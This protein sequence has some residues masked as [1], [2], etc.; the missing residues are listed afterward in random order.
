MCTRI[1]EIVESKA[2]I[3][4]YCFREKLMIRILKNQS[5]L[6]SERSYTYIFGI[7]SVNYYVSVG[8]FQ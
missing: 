3:F 8:W 1:P 7:H 2:D 4:L 6:L 5:Y